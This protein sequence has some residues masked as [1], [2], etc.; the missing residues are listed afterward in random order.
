M[1]RRISE[2]RL[3]SNGSNKPSE[4]DIPWYF[5][6]CFVIIQVYMYAVVFIASVFTITFIL[7]GD[8][9]EQKMGLPFQRR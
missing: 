7:G 5:F 6:P 2:Q 1:Q 8:S 9:N 4:L 3:L